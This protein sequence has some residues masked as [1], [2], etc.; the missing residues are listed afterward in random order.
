[1]SEPDIDSLSTMRLVWPARDYLAEYV[2]A[3]ER[4]WSPDNLRQEA[5]QE[6]LARIAANADAFLASLVDREAAGE[7]FV[8]PDG[9][10]VPRL[11]GYR[12]WMWDG[13][14]CGSASLRWQPGTEALPR[15]V[16]ATLAIPSCH[17]NAV[18]DM[19]RRRWA[20]CWSMRKPRGFAM[21][22]S[23]RALTT[24]RRSESFSPTGAC[25]W[26]SS[27]R[28]PLSAAIVIF[29][30]GCSSTSRPGAEHHV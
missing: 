11:P 5:A 16:S 10:S 13:E 28:R 21:S 4:G 29:A 23:R 1:M 30:I 22:R 6:E 14:F 17:G 15:T 25:S 24:S 9:S 3:L 8:F 19:P 2:A 20:S 12:M 7:R 18:V 26:K 27:P